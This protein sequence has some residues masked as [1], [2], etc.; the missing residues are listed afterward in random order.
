MANSND[1]I[2]K[3]PRLDNKLSSATLLQIPELIEQNKPYFDFTNVHHV[4]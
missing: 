1:K 4:A 3:N 2:F